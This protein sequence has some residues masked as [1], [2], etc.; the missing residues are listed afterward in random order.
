VSGF[1]WPGLMRHGLRG[2][3]LAPAEFWALTPAE[4]LVKLGLDGG[5]AAPLNRARMFELAARFPDV[6]KGTDDGDN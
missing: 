3:G 6:K 1:D 2:L 5:Q 4:L